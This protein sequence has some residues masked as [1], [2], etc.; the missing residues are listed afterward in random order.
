M[1]NIGEETRNRPVC[2]KVVKSASN[3]LLLE[4]GSQQSWNRR[5]ST[6]MISQE[7]IC[8]PSICLDSQ[9]T[10]KSGGGE[11]AFSDNSN[12]N[13]ANPKVVPRNPKSFSEIILPLK[14]DLLKVLKTNRIFLSKIEQCN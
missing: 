9:S 7:S 4:A 3:L 5:S 10:G 2:F 1:P 13:L 8:I 14:E 12:S 11:S 6:E